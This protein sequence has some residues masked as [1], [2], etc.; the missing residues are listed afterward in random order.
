V[1]GLIGKTISYY[2]ILEQIGQGGMS[3]VFSAVDLRDQRVVAV[4]VLSPYIAHEARFKARFDREIKLLVRLQHPNIMPI[5]DYGEADGLAFIIMPYIGTGTL[6]DRL[7]KGPLDPAVGSRIVQ[8][9]ASALAAAHAAGVVHRDV[10][11]SNVLVDPMGNAL[12]SDFSFAHQADASQNLTGSALIGTPA[13]MSPEQ[14]RGEPIDAR[15]DQYALAVVLYQ[16]ATG[17][18]PFE[19]DTPMATALKHVNEPLPRPRLVNPSIPE[20][21]E[22]VLVRG[23]AKDPALRYGSVLELDDAFQEALRLALDPARRIKTRDVSR[24]TAM[25]DKYQNVKPPPRRPWVGRT[26][27]AAALLALLACPAAAAAMAAFYPGLLSGGVAAAPAALD[28]QGTVDVLLTLNAP[29]PGTQLAPGVM[30]TA[31]YL[32]VVQTLSANGTPLMEPGL[33]VVAL[34]AGSE[35]TAAPLPFTLIF[36][37]SPP[38]ATLTLALGESPSPPTVTPSPTRTATFGPS[39]TFGPT[40]GSTLVILQTDVGSSPTAATASQPAPTAT[41]AVT[42]TS[43]PSA[44]SAP[45]SAPTSTPV[46]PT[47]TNPPPPTNTSAP[48]PTKTPK[49]VNPNACNSNPGHP[50]YCTPSP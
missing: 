18:L 13:Y 37:T 29:P 16:I 21:V 32:A 11:P 47:S 41:A 44:T 10:K 25:Y 15:S 50:N 49:P 2:T 42:Q 30:Q 1:L 22:L 35:G 33:E 7:L 28:V 27:V 45:T 20:E 26:A 14:C 4:K 5:L 23:L 46:P 48:E 12:L 6:G 24:S 19:A 31:I 38:A 36:P 40:S 39:P 17:R 8:Q 9:L 34:G 3:S 43:A